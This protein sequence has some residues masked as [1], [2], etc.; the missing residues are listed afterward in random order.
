MCRTQGRNLT[1]YVFREG[2]NVA[3]HTLDYIVFEASGL[4]YN[5]L[6]Y[7]AEKLYK[8]TLWTS[9]STKGP[10]KDKSLEY[11]QQALDL[12]VTTPILQSLGTNS[13]DGSKEIMAELLG[14]S[15]GIN[16]EACC[17]DMQVQPLFSPY[18]CIK[19]TGKNIHLFYIESPE[20]FILLVVDFEGIL[21][22]ADIVEK[23][24]TVA[25]IDRQAIIQT[26]ANYLLDFISRNL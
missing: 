1:D 11:I 22:R 10:Q 17:H 24:D 2:S 14:S 7:M 21:R 16:W 25:M 4:V 20:A 5:E 8:D 15:S 19:G 13:R 23:D 18:W 3:M 9:L 12:F 6:S 26:F